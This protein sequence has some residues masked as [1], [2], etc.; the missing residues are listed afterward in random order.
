MFYIVETETQLRALEAYGR[1][2]CYFRLILGNDYYHPKLTTPVAVYIRPLHLEKGF[3]IPINHSEG[4]NVGETRVLQ[5][6]SAFKDKY[7][8]DSKS[9]IYHWKIQGIYDLS[10]LYSMLYYR[11][12]ELDT[13]S[14]TVNWF[15]RR[16]GERADLNS[17][18]PLSKLYEQYE[19]EY[20]QIKDLI[21][22]DLPEGYDFY[23][24]IAT[25]IFFL[26]EQTGLRV[27]RH[28]F[29]E[30]YTPKVPEYSIEDET[31][32][33]QYNLC[34]LTSRPTN[35]FN[36]VNFAAIPKTEQSREV[37]KPFYDELVEFDFDGYHVRLISEQIGYPLTEEPAHSQL[38]RLYFGTDVVTEEYYQKAKSLNFQLIYGSIPEAYQNLDFS[39][40][41]QSFIGSLWEKYKKE[42][43]IVDP[44]SG[45]AFTKEIEK[46]HEMYPKKLFNYYIQSLETSK[47]IQK[48]MKVLKELQGKKSK[49]VLYTYDAIVLDYSRDDG[50]SLL[51]D[52]KSLLEEGSFPVKIKRSNNLVF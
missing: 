13:S 10:I 22:Q 20:S 30:R 50:E 6:L 40:K 15:F 49:I 36:S 16:F 9:L 29:I 27:D 3:I 23:N 2:G 47:N 39:K 5:V 34:N 35:A 26:V 1:F 21:K 42:G 52:I 28:T 7:T 4:L 8:L 17:I 38:A 12:L 25:H 31:V 37:F 18:I 43:K 19:E 32:Y 14:S 45:K 33:T 46:I 51:T 24:R 11:K 48:L 41:I 44:I